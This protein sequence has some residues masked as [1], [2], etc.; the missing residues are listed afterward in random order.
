VNPLYEYRGWGCK[1]S[2]A[3][4]GWTSVDEDATRS[5]LL[6]SPFPN[7]EEPD[8]YVYIG[9]EYVQNGIDCVRQAVVNYAVKGE[10]PLARGI[11]TSYGRRVAP[12]PDFMQPR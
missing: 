5:A 10:E 1:H 12:L 3:K 7:R 11:V 6:T 9:P 2:K 8:S 4:H